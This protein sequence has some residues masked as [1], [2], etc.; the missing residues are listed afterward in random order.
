MEE[1]GSGPKNMWEKVFDHRLNP[2]DKHV[3][4]YSHLLI[5]RLQS[6]GTNQKDLEVDRGKLLVEMRTWISAM[7]EVPP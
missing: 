2:G 6:Q 3:S 5:A 4:C 1:E 7:Q